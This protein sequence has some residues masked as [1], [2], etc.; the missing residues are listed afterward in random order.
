MRLD[1]L[2]S[3]RRMVREL[4]G[5]PS[6]IDLGGELRKLWEDIGEYEELLR[7]LR[8]GKIDEASWAAT[9]SSSVVSQSTT[10]VI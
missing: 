10:G 8:S 5:V 1:L 2:L 9:R 7:D 3:H 4:L 6:S